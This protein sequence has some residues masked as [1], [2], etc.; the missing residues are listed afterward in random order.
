MDHSTHDA[1]LVERRIPEPLLY[2]GEQLAGRAPIR[3]RRRRDKARLSLH[4][5][6]A[7]VLVSLTAWWVVPRHSFAGPVVLSLSGGHGVHAGDLPCLVFLAV[8]ARSAVQACRLCL[9][10]QLFLDATP[11][12]ASGG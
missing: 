9:D 5:G 7:L 10:G 6:I 3:L 1:D 11:V 12:L 4:L 2:T 8:A